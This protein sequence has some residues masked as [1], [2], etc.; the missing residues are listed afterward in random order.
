[1]KIV[2][3]VW[4]C[5]PRADSLGAV[6]YTVV[7]EMKNIPVALAVVASLFAFGCS[8]PRFSATPPDDADVAVKQT[9]KFPEGLW[10]PS[11]AEETFQAPIL[12]KV[13]RPVHPV[14]LNGTG[15]S[16]YAIIVYVIDE[17]GETTNVLV[18]EASNRYFAHAARAAVQVWK[19]RPAFV[20]GKPVAMKA[21]QKFQFEEK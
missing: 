2:I 11:G 6:P 3:W 7:I 16:G 1:M 5:T 15:V 10:E 14:Q 8:G 13:W 19:Y 9:L 18:R 21:E 12:F 20:N 4:P 17:N